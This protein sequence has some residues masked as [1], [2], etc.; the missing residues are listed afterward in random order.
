MNNLGKFIYGVGFVM[1]V[2]GVVGLTGIALKRN[3]DCYKAEMK[4]VTTEGELFLA[5]LHNSI[6]DRQIEELQK[7]ISELKSE[8][9]KES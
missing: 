2:I 9:E 4:L 3:K 5:N 6:K 1:E 7:E 8:K